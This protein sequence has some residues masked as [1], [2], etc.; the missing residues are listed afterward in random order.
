MNAY[1][2]SGQHDIFKKCVRVVKYYTSPVTD[3]LRKASLDL[4]II[5]L[6]S[7]MSITK[8]F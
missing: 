1:W 6:A 4:E 3:Q 7:I 2:R 8:C 5:A